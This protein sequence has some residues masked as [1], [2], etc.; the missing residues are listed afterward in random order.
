MRLCR[1]QR[2][3]KVEFGFLIDDETLVPVV[4]VAHAIGIYEVPAE[5]LLDLLPGGDLKHVTAK[6]ES[7]ITPE[8]IDEHKVATSSVK[9]LVP[10]AVPGKLILLAG[11]YADHVAERGGIAEERA[12]TFPYLFMKPLTTLTHPG[13]PIRIPAVSP[14]EIDWE[15]ELGVILGKTCF[16]VTAAD[17]LSYV[18]GYTVIND[19]SDRAFH[20]NPGRK[21]RPKDAFFDWQ[22]GKWHDTFC[23]MGPCVL[24]AYECPD[25]QNLRMTLTVNEQVEQDASTGE[26]IFPV[27]D[28]ISFVSQFVTLHPGDIIATGTPAG[29][30]KAKG[31]FLKSG[32]LVTAKIEKIGAL[33]NPVA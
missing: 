20:P 29:V 8:I 14:H 31:R 6:L 10:I 28:I 15:I 2:A 12:N 22:H 7:S 11:N 33:K 21:T 13:D 3:D 24:P 17:A 30:G 1:F 9:L 27:A 5:T 26:M 19:V 23:P 18:A 16:G 32:D 25:P 4:D